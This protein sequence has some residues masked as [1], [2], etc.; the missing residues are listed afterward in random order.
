M[1][2]QEA[3]AALVSRKV[4]RSTFSDP[5]PLAIILDDC[6]YFETHSELI[7]P[8][9]IAHANRLLQ[10]VG[11]ISTDPAFIARDTEARLLACNDADLQS[12]INA[13]ETAKEE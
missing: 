6:G 2:R 10:S 5:R 13:E 4:M 8:E 12:I 7:N 3:E 11:I 9:L 1:N